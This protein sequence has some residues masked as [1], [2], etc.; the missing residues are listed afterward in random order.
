M[1]RVSRGHPLTWLNDEPLI[2]AG[3][4]EKVRDYYAADWQ[5]CQ[6]Y[7]AEQSERLGVK[8]SATAK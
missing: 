5:A 3:E 8:R 6:D 1:G 7:V 2:A 4:L